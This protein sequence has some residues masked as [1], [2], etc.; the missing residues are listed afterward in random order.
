MTKQDAVELL[1]KRWK[2]LEP[3]YGTLTQWMKDN[4]ITQYSLESFAKVILRDK[5]PSFELAVKLADLLGMSRGQLQ[6]IAMC[7]EQPL[8]ADLLAEVDIPR[9][10]A[11]LAK[12][13]MNLSPKSRKAVFEIVAA[14]EV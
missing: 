3:S 11:E 1:Q 14:L 12:R 2:E 10:E 4:Q 13:I 6:L 7:Y 5:I 8:F 9:P